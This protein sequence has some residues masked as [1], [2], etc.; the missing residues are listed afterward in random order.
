M[1]IRANLRI[2]RGNIN[3]KVNH[4]CILIELRLAKQVSIR[5]H[6]PSANEEK[7]VLVCKE[8]QTLA[9]VFD[10]VKEDNHDTDDDN[11]EDNLFPDPA[12]F[13]P[14]SPDFSFPPLPPTPPEL[15]ETET[16]TSSTILKTA[17]EVL[18]SK[19][20]EKKK[21]AEKKLIE[22]KLKDEEDKQKFENKKIKSDKQKPEKKEK[23]SILVDRKNK[24]QNNEKKRNK[25]ESFHHLKVPQV[26]LQVSSEREI[27]D[28]I[29]VIRNKAEKKEEKIARRSKRKK[30]RRDQEFDQLHSQHLINC[31]ECQEEKVK[32]KREREMIRSDDIGQ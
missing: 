30:E 31:S 27:V 25:K 20:E 11:D 29:M 4:K 2:Y 18:P 8:V 26:Q 32:K 5:V 13:L 10:H 1:L 9:P 6:E 15:D 24:H 17:I 23:T 3:Y 19:L 12:E 16:I 7:P 28:S 14:Q 22:S 21:E